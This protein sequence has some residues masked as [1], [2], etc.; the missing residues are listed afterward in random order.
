MLDY[1]HVP[2]TSTDYSK[3]LSSIYMNCVSYNRQTARPTLDIEQER[4]RNHERQQ[5]DGIAEDRHPNADCI[6]N[7]LQ[8][9]AERLKKTTISCLDMRQLAEK[10][11]LDIISEPIE[12]TGE[13]KEEIDYT[14]VIN[15][16]EKGRASDSR[17]RQR[18]LWKDTY[19]V[20]TQT[21]SALMFEFRRKIPHE[22]PLPSL[23]VSQR[24]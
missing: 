23:P 21:R 19:F 16:I 8:Q 5:L 12:P 20:V 13:F 2:S 14:S 18:S 17:A 10:E 15:H 11:L 3:I 6:R 22:F 7:Q 1:P 9:Y 24:T 4:L